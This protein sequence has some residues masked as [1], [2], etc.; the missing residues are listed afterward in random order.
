MPVPISP[1][2]DGLEAKEVVY[3]KDQ[4]EYSPLPTLRSVSG[5]VVS[6]WRLTKRE[7]DAIASGADIFLYV[8]TFNHPLQPVAIEVVEWAL[9]DAEAMAARLGLSE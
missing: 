1:V 6:R 2:I 5:V 9:Q 8:H 4:P 7:C 3:A